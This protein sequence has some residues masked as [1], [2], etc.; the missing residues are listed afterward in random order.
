MFIDNVT[1][2]VGGAIDSED[3][4]LTISDSIFVNNSSLEVSAIMVSSK[5]SVAITNCVISNNRGGGSLWIAGNPATIS[6][7][8][9]TDN[10][11]YGETPIRTDGTVVF[12][13]CMITGGIGGDSGAIYNAGALTVSNSTLTGNRGEIAGAILNSGTLNISNSTITGNMIFPVTGRPAAAI[14]NGP[15]SPV[16]SS[17]VT[18]L[19]QDSTIA[20]NDGSQIY[21]GQTFGSSSYKDTIQVHSTILSSNG[22][23]PNVLTG[24]GGTLVSLGHNL[25]T[26]SGGGLLTGPG[27][28]TN[29]NP[30]L[31][32][33]Q[34]N[35]GPTQTMA[36]LPGSPAVDTGDNIGAPVLDQRGYPRIVGGRIDIGAYEVQPGPAT[37]FQVSAPAHVSAGVPFNIS[38]TAIDAYGHTAVGYVGTVVFRSSDPGPGVVLPSNYT[39]AL[40]DS[41]VHLF[42]NGGT[43]RTAGSQTITVMDTLTSSTT[44]STSLVVTLPVS[45][46]LTDSVNPSIY[47]Q[48]VTITATVSSAGSPVSS[49]TVTFKEGT[50]VLAASVPVDSNGHASFQV[51]SLT[52]AGSPH[53]ITASYSGTATFEPN[54]GNL[55]QTVNKAPLLVT[56]DDQ[57]RMY[58]Q[59]NPAFTARYT[60]FVLGENLGHQPAAGRGR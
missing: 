21:S 49:G 40:G 11:G 2:D 23:K 22:A 16:Q 57:S 27:D 20:G 19:V 10:G 6:N 24:T 7:C 12:T 8:T 37:H 56:A 1:E 34:D 18:A 60:G 15:D 58:G 14:V 44:G 4:P 47:G 9:I 30:L 35:G 46:V 51:A 31:G 50:T 36:L 53:T 55:T 43:L 59:S 28:V 48:P 29:K 3:A 32:P 39:F 13:N 54:S 17:D 5:S 25:S 38:L 42:S 45:L 33:L 26:D 52:A 41:G